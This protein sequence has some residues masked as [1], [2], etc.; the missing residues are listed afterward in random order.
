MLNYPPVSGHCLNSLILLPK[1]GGGDLFSFCLLQ[2]ALQ[3]W[4]PFGCSVSSTSVLLLFP[5]LMDSS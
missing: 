2:G 3:S 1:G 4:A 5:S